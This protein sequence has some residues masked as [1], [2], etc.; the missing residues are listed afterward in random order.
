MPRAASIRMAFCV[1]QFVVHRFAWIDTNSFTRCCFQLDACVSEWVTHTQNHKSSNKMRFARIDLY[2]NVKHT[3]PR[4]S[5]F[6]STILC[7]AIWAFGF[8]DG[9]HLWSNEFIK[10]EKIHAFRRIVKRD[11]SFCLESSRPSAGNDVLTALCL[12][13]GQNRNK[14]ITP[15]APIKWLIW[16]LMDLENFP[17]LSH[18]NDA[19]RLA[20]T[21]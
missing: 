10:I 4:V 14:I 5:I 15:C 11:L 21:C 18:L 13:N 16:W 17:F 9:W 19:R 7:R 8:I 2:R 6:K 20:A 12:R 3:V 1:Q